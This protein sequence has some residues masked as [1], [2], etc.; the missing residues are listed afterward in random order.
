[1]WKETEILVNTAVC[2]DVLSR[3][4][5]AQDG[6]PSQFSPLLVCLLAERGLHAG[7]E[8]VCLLLKGLVLL[9]LGLNVALVRLGVVRPTL[10]LEKVLHLWNMVGNEHVA[11]LLGGS[12]L[13][14]ARARQIARRKAENK[15]QRLAFQLGRGSSERRATRAFTNLLEKRHHLVL[16]HVSGPV[17]GGVAGVVAGVHLGPEAEQKLRPLD[18]ADV[19]AAVER[20]VPRG[21]DLVDVDAVL[22]R[23][24]DRLSVGWETNENSSRISSLLTAT[25]V[26]RP[27][28]LSS[29][30][31]RRPPTAPSYLWRP[32]C[33][34]RGG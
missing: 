17:P 21:L 8:L 32:C 23:L 29:G 11:L 31:S 26:Q 9:L 5:D 10:L 15:S 3:S 30:P 25:R 12:A 14:G 22:N 27:G 1:M 28:R 6:C 13:R 7:D 4:T 24:L 18:P 19:R 16:P 34:R 2:D 20:G 33:S